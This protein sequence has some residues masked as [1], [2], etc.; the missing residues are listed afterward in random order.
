MKV[1]SIKGIFPIFVTNVLNGYRNNHYDPELVD[2]DIPFLYDISR[3]CLV[4]LFSYFSCK[5]S[6][7]WLKV[8]FQINTKW[9][10]WS[11]GW[12]MPKYKAEQKQVL[13]RVI[14][15]GKY[16]TIL[17]SYTWCLIMAVGEKEN[18]VLNLSFPNVYG[19]ILL[20]FIVFKV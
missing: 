20:Y 14:M 1:D 16:Y 15:R 5:L 2:I 7:A 3:S 8:I 17:T 19:R 4:T 6:Y 9:N 11:E 10:I 18:R 13:Q 12:V